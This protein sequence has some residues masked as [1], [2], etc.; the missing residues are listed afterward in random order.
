MIESFPFISIF[1][2]YSMYQEQGEDPA[3]SS[4]SDD[5]NYKSDDSSDE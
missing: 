4:D 3:I 2:R 1:F 5:S